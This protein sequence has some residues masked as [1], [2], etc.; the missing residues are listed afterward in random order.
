MEKNQENVLSVDGLRKEYTKDGKQ[1]IVALNDISFDLKAGEILGMIGRNGSGK[2]TLL[3]VLS[4]ITGVSG[5]SI[6]HEGK[7]TSI[8]EIGTGFHPDLTG[9][10]NIKLSSQLLGVD[11][12]INDLYNH[13]V[14]FSGLDDF[15]DMPIKHYSSG[16][17]LR[18]AFSIAFHSRVD[19][20]LLDEVLAVGDANFRR[21]CYDK[22][23]E[24]KENGASILLVSHQ[25]E[26]IIEFCD[27]C[28]WLDNG[29]IMDA[30]SPLDVI[31]N[32]LNSSGRT[33]GKIGEALHENVSSNE[34]DLAALS[35]PFLRVHD[36]QV[37]AKGKSIHDDIQ[38]SDVIQIA[39]SCEKLIEEESIEFVFTLSNINNIR[40]LTDSYGL[41]EIYEPPILEKGKY[42]II[43]EI[44]AQLLNRGVYDLGIMICKNAKDQIADVQQVHRFKVTP[45][46]KLAF[47]VQIS[48]VIRPHLKWEIKNLSKK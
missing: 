25:M 3:K 30:G 8:I 47:D 24:L 48:T 29:N 27:R 35:T 2:S 32:Y 14:A 42:E 5:G 38:M 19:I 34:I 39:I 9:S 17:Y 1:I 15:M 41:R 10:E 20:L 36:I 12:R 18:L 4:K 16:M 43:C 21:K 7:L 26:P 37:R 45:G 23:R 6:T 22:I 33:Q 28:I 13:I 40:V 44:P 46:K 31:E 11:V